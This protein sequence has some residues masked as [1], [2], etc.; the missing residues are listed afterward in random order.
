MRRTTLQSLVFLVIIF[1]IDD[2]HDVGKAALCV[3]CHDIFI[4]IRHSATVG[5]VRLFDVRRQHQWR[6]RYSTQSFPLFVVLPLLSLSWCPGRP[7][8]SLAMD[9]DLIAAAG[10]R[11]LLLL[12]TEGEYAFCLSFAPSSWVLLDELWNGFGVSISSFAA[13]CAERSVS[14]QFFFVKVGDAPPRDAL[15]WVKPDVHT[16]VRTKI[17]LFVF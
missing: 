3:A 17:F 10:V 4:F 15:D 11:A 16:L 8:S 13:L 12:A 9:L 7:P 6:K 5:S 2:G 14:F 1:K